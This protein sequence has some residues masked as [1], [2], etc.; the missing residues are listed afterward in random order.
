MDSSCMMRC[1]SCAPI[2]QRL[3]QGTLPS[4][5]IVSFRTPLKG[6]V[7][8]TEA[9]TSVSNARQPSAKVVGRVGVEPTT[10]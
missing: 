4:A 10:R 1:A 6:V 7:G 9:G 2:S 8:E 3:L 5:W